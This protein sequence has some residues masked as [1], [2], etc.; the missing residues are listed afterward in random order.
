MKLRQLFGWW[1]QDFKKSYS[2]NPDEGSHFSTIWVVFTT[3]FMVLAAI[4][5]TDYM[6]TLGFGIIIFFCFYRSYKNFRKETK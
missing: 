6:A 4:P 1:K 5:P 3:P 2:P